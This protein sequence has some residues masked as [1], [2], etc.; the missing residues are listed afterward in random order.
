MHSLLHKKQG[1]SARRERGVT[2]VFTALAIVALLGVM[3]LAI[4]LGVLY[5]ARSEAQ[6]TADAAA[7]AG[8]QIFY[9]EGCVSASGGCVAGGPQEA[10]AAA[11]AMSVASQNYL[12]GKPA[13]IN[14]PEYAT[15]SSGGSCP[16]IS[17]AY[18]SSE[19][20]Q[21]TVTV[22]RSGIPTIFAGVFG[23][24]SGTVSATASA[25]A[26]NPEAAGATG[27]A[28]NSAPACVAPFLVPNC[29]PFS[30]TSTPNGVCPVQPTGYF[31]NPNTTPATLDYSAIGKEW[32]LHFGTGPSDAAVPSEWY[33]DAIWPSGTPSKSEV[34]N[35]IQECVPVTCGEQLPAVPGKG[36]GPVDQGVE[37]R[38]DASGASSSGNYNQGQDTIVTN[39]ASAPP[40]QIY[41]G[42]NNPLV[43]AGDVT[44]GSA[45]SPQQ[46]PSVVTVAL[47]D[48]AVCGVTEPN[49]TI[50]S[51]SNSDCIGSGGGTVT[52]VGWM[53]LF[54]E[55]YVHSGNNDSVPSVVMSMTPC[56]GTSGTGGSGGNGGGSG[57]QT[58]GTVANA[59]APGS[60]PIPI[61]L[62]QHAD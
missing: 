59:T 1:F 44:A 16:G 47:Y 10:S 3:A 11:K 50:E 2:L 34:R 29:D 51:S 36:V 54:L 35:A 32:D 5:V 4:D 8:A 55:G 43:V 18:P 25:E 61:R 17:F 48:G 12:A 27:G 24:P 20:P 53:T 19:E 42:S 23:A 7:L 30:S 57:G 9:T 6:R 60:S 52:V 49:G 26:Y 37:D 31:V 46:S 21:I 41:A 38:I 13:S 62:I 33:L 39:S 40:Y 28:A 22:V 58:G 15:P 56:N 14:C 45:I